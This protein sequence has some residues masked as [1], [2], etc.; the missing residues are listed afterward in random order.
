[1]RR[2]AEEGCLVM[3]FTE[4]LG[5]FSSF[6]SDIAPAIN[7]YLNKYLVANPNWYRTSN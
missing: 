7:P 3:S 5:R 1:M 6:A 4:V 2:V